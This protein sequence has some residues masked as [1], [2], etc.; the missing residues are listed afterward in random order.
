MTRRRTILVLITA[1]VAL[2]G[3]GMIHENAA[4]SVDLSVEEAPFN[5]MRMPLV[6]VDSGLWASSHA[7]GKFIRV[8]VCDSRETIHHFDFP[9]DSTQG[10]VPY[11]TVLHKGQPMKDPARAKKICLRLLR[12]YNQDIPNEYYLITGTRA[13]RQSRFSFSI[14]R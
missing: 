11:Q 6:S 13:P 3:A 8:I 7:P 14:F 2:A 5:S 1:V 10:G 12:T 9:E 4:L